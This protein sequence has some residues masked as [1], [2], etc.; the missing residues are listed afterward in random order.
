MPDNST[1]SEDN[2]VKDM[3]ALYDA[4]FLRGLKARG[5]DHLVVV[6][7]MN[8]RIEHIAQRMERNADAT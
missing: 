7:V 2:Q 1:T 6:R 3:L 5:Q 8:E 4:N